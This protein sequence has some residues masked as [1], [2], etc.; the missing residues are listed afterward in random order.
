MRMIETP[1]YASPRMIDHWIGAAP[2]SLGQQR[3]VH[4]ERP[5]PRQIQ[6]RLRQDPPVGDHD[7]HIGA[8]APPARR[9]SRACGSF[10][11]AGSARPA[12]AAALHRR[13]R[14]RLPAPRRAIRLADHGDQRRARPRRRAARAP[15][16]PATRR[17]P[18]AAHAVTARPSRQAARVTRT[19][20]CRREHRAAPR[21]P[22]SRIASSFAPS[23]PA[24]A[25]IDRVG[26]Q[27]ADNLFVRALQVGVARVARDA[28]HLEVVAVL[29]R[30]I[31]GQQARAR[32]SVWPPPE[33]AARRSSSGR[34]VVELA[35]ALGR[36][37]PLC[38]WRLGAAAPRRQ[39]G[40][41]QCV[42]AGAE[43][44]EQRVRVARRAHRRAAARR[45][46][47]RPSGL[48]DRGPRRVRP[49][50]GCGPLLGR[51]P[52]GSGP[53]G[54]PQPQLGPLAPSRPLS[55][56]PA[57]LTGRGQDGARPL[58]QHVRRDRPDEKSVGESAP[59]AARRRR[60][61]RRRSERAP[62][63]RTR[64][65]ASA[66]AGFGVDDLRRHDDELGGA[67]R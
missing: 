25:G 8:R 12:S 48:S 63:A 52:G 20:A 27:L 65:L 10:R 51:T 42:D 7:E 16:T 43:L 34:I 11:A 58:Q 19:Q 57:P 67:R 37:L 3:G 45:R 44:G 6:Q 5:E 24:S 62:A 35:L 32:A 40:V 9:A 46:P 59:A 39:L 28:Q 21:P 54:R 13:R 56:A 61:R 18:R 31:A 4:V 66:S 41:E 14:R 2:R 29:D 38:A 49:P 1:V 33:R 30:R 23:S 55:V 36:P 17:R 47:R 53:A 15:R 60:H 22:T 50:A 26:G 64:T